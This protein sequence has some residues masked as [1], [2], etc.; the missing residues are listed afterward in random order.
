MPSDPPSNTPPPS[1]GKPRRRPSPGV[2]GNWVW[3]VIL[4][5]LGLMFFASNMNSARR[6]AWSDFYVQLEKGNVKKLED[7]KSVV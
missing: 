2:G 4:L 6:I 1:S 5:L 3:M 7:R